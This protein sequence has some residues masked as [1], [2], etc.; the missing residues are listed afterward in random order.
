[1]PGFKPTSLLKPHRP[2]LTFSFYSVITV[3]VSTSMVACGILV[4]RPGIEP[5]APSVRAPSPNHWTAEE[6]LYFP[7]LKKK[8][9]NKSQEGL[10]IMLREP[11]F[12]C[13]DP[14]PG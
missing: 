7:A 5:G 11:E 13:V 9:R 3:R 8:I 14:E 4:P 12:P 2:C 6:F 1:M 10:P